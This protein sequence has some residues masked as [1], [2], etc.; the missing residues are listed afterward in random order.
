MVYVYD[1]VAMGDTS[2]DTQRLAGQQMSHGEGGG[3]GGGARGGGG[4]GGI[5]PVAR[6]SERGHLTRAET[7]RDTQGVGGG[8]GGGGGRGRS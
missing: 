7:R 3:G 2:R 4:G 8:G 6:L 5:R 1:P